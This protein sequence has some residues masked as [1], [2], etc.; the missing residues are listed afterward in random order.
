MNFKKVLISE[1][2]P[3]AYN[4][5]KKLTEKD[6]EYQR[7]KKSIEEFG[8]VDPIIVN[9]D[10]TVIGGHQRLAVLKE[11]GETKIDVVVVDID[12]TREKALNI[13]L[14]KIVGEWDFE[15]LSIVL[16]ELKEENFDI[17]ITGFTD[18]ELKDIDEDLFGKQAKEDNYEPPPEIETTIKRGD[19]I[20]LGKHR[21]MCGDSTSKEDVEKLMDGNKADMVF[22]DPPYGVA[23][24]DKN[25]LLNKFQKSGRNLTPIENDSLGEKEL[26][27]LLKSAFVNTREVSAD[28]MTFYVTVPQGGSLGMMMMMMSDS[29]LPVRHILIWVKNSPTFSLGRLDYDYQHEPIFYGWLKRHTFYGKGEFTKSVWSVDK[30]RKSKEHPTMKPVALPANAIQNSSLPDQIILD[31][32]LGSGTTL[33]ACEQLDRVCYGMEISPQYCEVICQRWEKLTGKKRVIVGDT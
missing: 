18:K 8:Y 10:Y 32:F 11:M 4:P 14:N 2:K 31:P 15:Q 21:V 12:K 19:I 27:D 23:I 25:K 26:Y 17:S 13:A 3:A 1:L 33:I 6:P 16:S 24:G 22:T 29:G 28:H 9:S 20:L 30:P 7:I 5:R